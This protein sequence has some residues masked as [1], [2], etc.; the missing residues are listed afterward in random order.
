[1]IGFA[2]DMSYNSTALSVTAANSSFLLASATG[3]STFQAGDETAL[4]DADGEYNAATIDTGPIPGSTESGSGVLERVTVHVD[5]A[6]PA[7]GYP[8]HLIVAAHTD[9]QN[10]PHDGGTHYSAQLAVGVMCNTLTL[11]EPP[12]SKNG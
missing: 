1:M 12:P 7:G 6:A 5:A 4:P 10:T 9:T 3:S 11:P 2:F 8:L